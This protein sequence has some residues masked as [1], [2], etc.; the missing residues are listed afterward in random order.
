MLLQFKARTGASEARG[1]HR[2]PGP[3]GD[4]L[5]RLPA[6]TNSKSFSLARWRSL[7]NTLVRRSTQPLVLD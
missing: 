4:P 3:A 5:D 1:R 2:Q 6:G 7:S